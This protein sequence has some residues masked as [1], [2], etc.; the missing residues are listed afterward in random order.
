MK[1]TR[2]APSPSGR[3]HLGHAYSAALGH[4][5]ARSSGGQFLLRIEDLDLGRCRPEFV[6]GII[7][8]LDWLGLGY[9]GEAIVQSERTDVYAQALE[10]LKAR[11]LVYAC[12]CTR[13][14]IAQSLTAPHG[15]AGSQYPGTCRRLPDDPE[16]RASTPHCWRLDSA[17][18]LAMAGLPGWTEHDGTLFASRESDF[19]DAILAR[20]DAPSSYHLSCVVDDAASG[21]NLVVRGEDLR[22]STPTQRLLQ[23]LLGLPEPTYFHHPLITHDDGRRLAKRDLAPTLE[24]LRNSGVDGPGLVKQLLDGRLPL[25]F[26]LSEA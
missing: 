24:A 13:A 2:F 7:E 12:F 4:E 1:V 23:S 20:K 18:A 14:E 9:D 15:D 5:L 21:V 17:K 10:A 8:D 25:G 19:G 16:R 6:G 22:P 3:L 26:R 11:G